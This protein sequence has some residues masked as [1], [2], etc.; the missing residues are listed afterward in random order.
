M[1]DEKRKDTATFDFSKQD[2]CKFLSF[3]IGH[4]VKV[5]DGSINSNMKLANQQNCAEIGS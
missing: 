2:D 1:K 3:L 4:Q 5:L